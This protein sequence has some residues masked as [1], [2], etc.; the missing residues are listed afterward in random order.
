MR[1][2]VLLF[3]LA[4]ASCA[5][6]EHLQ[7]ALTLKDFSDEGE[8][9]AAWV[10]EQ[11]RRFDDLVS[12]VKAGKGD[13][14]PYEKQDDFVRRFGRPVLIKDA[15]GN[16][17]PLRSWLYRYQTKYSG[18]KVYVFFDAQDRMTDCQ[19]IPGDTD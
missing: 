5:K 10:R 15:T 2:F 1:P 17:R 13:F 7:E 8:A 12:W 9:T 4:F 6:L 19:Y 3:L 18:P 11:D 16:G 14:S